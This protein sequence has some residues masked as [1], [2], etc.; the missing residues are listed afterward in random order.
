M[1]VLLGKIRKNAWIFVLAV[2]G[3]LLCAFCVALCF[4]AQ[5]AQQVRISEVCSNNFSV[6]CDEDGKYSDYVE[7]YN[8]ARVPVSLTGF[9]LSDDK[10]E[11]GKCSFDSVILPPGGRFLV[12]LDGSKG[13]RVGHA[14]FKISSRGESVYLS[15]GTGKIIDYVEVPALSYNT[16]Y[17]RA[18]EDPEVWSRCLASAG[19]E[20]AKGGILPEP[21][22]EEP[23]FSAESG[24][25]GDAF[26]LT[27]EAGDDEVIYYTLDGSVPTTQS[28]LYQEPLVIKDASP[29]ENRYAARTDLAGV[30]DYIPAFCVD[31]ATVIRAIA[32]DKEKNAASP[33]A[34][35]TYFVGFD[36]KEE[37]A[38]YPVVSLVTDPDNLFDS[39]A[40]I[41]TN[42][43]AMEKYK[44][45]AGVLQ[46]GEIPE[47]YVGG[48]GNTNYLYMASN[49]FY[50]GREWER[51]AVLDYF[52]ETHAFDFS[53]GVG[54]R[55]AGQS[56]R[57]R[58]QKSFNVYARDIYDAGERLQSAF[59]NDARYTS[60]KLRNGGSDSEKSKI[61]DPFLQS[62]VR[63]REVS[64]QGCLP[65]ALFLN[66]EYWGLYNIRERYQEEY[67]ANH[68]KISEGNIW[69]IDSGEISIGSWDAW[70]AYDEMLRFV[71]ENDMADMGNYQKFCELMDVQSL[72]D[73]YCVQLYID[74]GD[75]GFDK[76]IALW[77][78]A[79]KGSG[80]YEDGRWRF[81]LYD[82]DGALGSP[83]TNTFS[84]SVEWKEDFDLMDET[85]IR[86]LLLNETFKKQF[87]DTFREMAENDF[88]YDRVHEKL[89]EWKERYERQAVKSHQRFVSENFSAGEYDRYMDEID[90]F[91]RERCDYI[92]KYMEEELGC[93]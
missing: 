6:I 31:K 7:L 51:E 25:Y 71:E 30:M 11:L 43:E 44:R 80:E 45:E 76:N 52:D 79:Q 90:N 8:P 65:C 20:N 42:G 53:Q 57:S 37:Y 61:M 13:D 4:S 22:L 59:F 10:Y 74:N 46:D 69:M 89:T 86:S 91:F 85:L 58:A 40:G 92:L 67:F 77:R 15:D 41:Y 3:F 63:D 50:R 49:A 34:T 47:A 75:V 16:V 28:F 68:Y 54:I 14:S 83:Q 35:R 56:T 39:Q 36:R 48:E 17:A 81:M 19:K 27:I 93:G 82:L 87:A 72:I 21:G 62:L 64:I 33:V 1:D 70:N 26:A 73:F 9:S 29:N 18:D 5:A 24:F 2:L 38:G 12:W 60:V 23:V 78:T 55:I 84:E 88:A 66:G 32:Y